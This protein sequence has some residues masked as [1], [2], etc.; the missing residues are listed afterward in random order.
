VSQ[1]SL[2][3]QNFLHL[4]RPRHWVKNLFVFIP[5]FFAAEIL[6]IPVFY[7]ALLVFVSFCMISST[8][9]IINDI[10]DRE[11][12]KLHP[13]KSKRPIASGNI[14]WKNALIVAFLLCVFGFFTAFSLNTSTF[15]VLLVY[16]A[17]NILY[18]FWLKHLVVV[19]LVIIGAGFLLRIYAGG[20][21]SDIPISFW[22]LIMVFLISIFMGL[23]KRR[24][25]VLLYQKTGLEIRKNIK[26]YN[27]KFIE[28][29]LSILAGVIVVTY[30]MYTLS[31]E[32]K[33]RIDSSYIHITSIFVIIGVMKYLHRIF[34]Q[35]KKGA[36][37][38][39]LFTDRIIQLALLGW[40]FTFTV[41]I[42][43]N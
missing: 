35:D 7:E 27:L 17:I 8:V 33:D 26:G 22:L 23:A 3:I 14:H 32:L 42:Y 38:T 21:A 39:V 24:D 40:L 31:P 20:V 6:N 41:L 11:Q 43:I 5:A 25:D 37:V 29:S 36:P 9:Y 28:T 30:I 19:N 18:S 2:S 10:R 13:E 1:T 34:T 4:L 16:L 15:E 12:D